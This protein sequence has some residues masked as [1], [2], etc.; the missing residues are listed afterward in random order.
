MNVQEA[1]EIRELNAAELDHVSGGWWPLVAACAVGAAAG[2][3][4]A[5]LTH[6]S[7]NLWEQ[8]VAY[9]LTQLEQNRQ[10]DRGKSMT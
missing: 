4:A 5:V 3:A 10:S 2:F 9:A 7:P 6:D 1:T 8:A